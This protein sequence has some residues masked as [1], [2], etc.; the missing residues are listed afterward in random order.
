MTMLLIIIASVL[1]VLVLAEWLVGLYY[2]FVA[3]EDLVCE[4]R[5]D[6]FYA[7]S[8]RRKPRPSVYIV[9]GGPD[10]DAA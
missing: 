10:D 2:R 4:M 1:A 7:E 3:L 6:Q 9:R 5:A 8:R